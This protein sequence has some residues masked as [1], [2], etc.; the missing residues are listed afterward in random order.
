M[1]LVVSIK[2]MFSL[3]FFRI[4]R[5]QMICFNKSDLA[6]GIIF[7]WLVGIGRYW[8][9]PGAKLFQHLGMGSIIY[10]FVLALFIWALFWPFKIDKWSYQNLL[11]FISLTSFPALLYAIP[12]E[13]FFELNI[14]RSINVYFLLVVAVWRVALLVFYL[15]R[16]ARISYFQTLVATLLPLTIIVTSLTALNL[17]RAVFN[18]MGGLGKSTSSDGAYGVLIALSVLSM[19]AVIP[20][21]CSYIIIVIRKY[22]STRKKVA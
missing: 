7:T 8:D 13:R 17:E 3:L 11:T 16:Y 4:T 10:I 21:I 22:K 6:V 18:I 14:A 20:L 1:N 5:D 2:K 9:D 12:V 15:R 19:Y